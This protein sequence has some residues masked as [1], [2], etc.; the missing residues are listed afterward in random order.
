M[1][2]FRHRYFEKVCYGQDPLISVQL[3]DS[4][5][6]NRG[7]TISDLFWLTVAQMARLDPFFPKSQGKPRVD[8]RRHLPEGPPYCGQLGSQKGGVDA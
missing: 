1:N 7:V 8:D 4:R 3:R 6:E 5:F 2:I